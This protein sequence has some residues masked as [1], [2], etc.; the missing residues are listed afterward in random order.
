[1]PV[2]EFCD[3][4][5]VD[6]LEDTSYKTVAGL[7]L[8][9]LAELPQVGQCIT[10]RDLQIEIVDMDGRRIDKLLVQSRV[11]EESA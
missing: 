3:R 7:V 6:F 9:H 1:M 4:M 2:D 5:G 11:A 8:H 10:I